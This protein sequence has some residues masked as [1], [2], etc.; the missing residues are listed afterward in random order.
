MTTNY[1]DTFIEIAEDCPVAKAE[2]PQ[3][4]GGK[5][6]KPVLEYEMITTHPHKRTQDDVAFE[7]HAVT[8]DIPKGNL[9]QEREKFFSV[10]RPCMRSSALAKR[11]G[12]GIYN[13][14]EGKLAL[15]AMDSP[16]YQRFI[17]DPHIKKVK[18]LRSKR[19]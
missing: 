12:W 6:T 2:I 18:A 15:V 9:P 8:H 17:N 11:Y 16:E 10:G 1:Y 19:A 5:K 14:T 13:D 7:V 3:P 4:K